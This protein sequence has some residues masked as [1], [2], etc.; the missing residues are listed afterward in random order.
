MTAP[1]PETLKL[2]AES[3]PD[4]LSEHAS[5]YTRLIKSIRSIETELGIEHRIGLRGRADM[6]TY[7][8]ALENTK[9]GRADAALTG[10]RRKSPVPTAAAPFVPPVVQAPAAPSGLSRGKCEAIA[11]LLGTST[12][13]V[14]KFSDAD[15]RESIERRAYQE[16]LRFPGMKPDAELAGK[17]WRKAET[18]DLTGTA[19]FIRAEQQQQIDNL[20]QI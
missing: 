2:L 8:R 19:R 14:G 17:H 3:S 4:A 9:A 7:L 15:L 12:M 5:E 11:V 10:N 6:R 13:D 16:N 1:S 18:K 20:V